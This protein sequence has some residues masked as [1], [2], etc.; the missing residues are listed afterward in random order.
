MEYNFYSVIPENLPSSVARLSEKAY[1]SGE[2]ATLFAEDPEYLELLD[3]V[4]WTFSSAAFIPHGTEDIGHPEQQAVWL[5][6]SC[7]NRNNSSIAILVNSFEVANWE[8]LHFSKIIFMFSDHLSQ[9]AI[10]LFELLQKNHGSVNYW[11]QTP[12]GW[13]KKF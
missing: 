5:T 13:V 11:N 8:D 2:H 7:E 4:L 1:L 6:T 3:K 9:S 12:K 10:N